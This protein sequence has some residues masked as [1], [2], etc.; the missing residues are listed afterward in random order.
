MVNMGTRGL[1]IYR[2]KN[3]KVAYYVSSD[4]YPSGVGLDLANSI[5]KPSDGVGWEERFQEWLNAQRLRVEQQIA[6]LLPPEQLRKT[7][8][9][10]YEVENDDGSFP[11]IFYIRR[12]P[13][14]DVIEWTYEIDLDN[15]CFLVNSRPI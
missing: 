3:V 2:Y 6:E 1:R 12:D 4:A 8:A 9:A 11:P 15:L 7:G 5:P 10:M 14:V 13:P